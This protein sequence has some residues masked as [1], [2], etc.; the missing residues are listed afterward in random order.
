MPTNNPRPEPVIPDHEVLRKIG[1]GSYG[2][3]WLARGVT[4]ALRAVKVVYREDFDDVRG[5]EREFEGILKFEPISRD[6]PGLV[7]ILHVGRSPDFSFY[8]YVMELGDDVTSGREINPIE[9]EART[10]SSDTKRTPGRRLATEHCIDCGLRLAEAL[11]HLHDG[12]LAHR[13]VKPSNVIFVNGKAKLADIGLVATRGQRTF[14]GTEG[15]VPPEG[16]GSAQADVY[17]LG[18]VLYEIATGKDRLDFPELPDELPG[19]AERKRWLALNQIICDICEPQLSKRTIASAGELADS[20]RRLQQGKRRK[21]RRRPVGAFFATLLVGGVLALGGWLAL[22]G[23]GLGQQI[24]RSNLG[25]YF[26]ESPPPPAPPKP[27]AQVLVKI[28][29]QPSGAHVFDKIKGKQLEDTPCEIVGPE[30][31]PLSLYLQLEGYNDQP[32]EDVI[33][34]NGEPMPLLVTLVKFTPPVPAQPWVFKQAYRPFGGV[35]D[36]NATDPRSPPAFYHETEGPV[37]K[38]PWEEYLKAKSRPPEVSEFLDVDAVGGGPKQGIVLTSESEANLYCQWLMAEG[39]KTGFLKE[40]HEITPVMLTDFNDPGLSE[41]ARKDGL[42]PF[43]CQVRL[44]TYATLV[45]S[46]IPGGAEVYLRQQSEGFQ[47]SKGVTAEG[48]PLAIPQI[49]PGETSISVIRE[50]YKPLNETFT[51]KPGETKTLSRKL[52]PNQSVVMDKPWENSLGMKF[53]P[54]AKDLMACVWETRVKDY[55]HYVS[56]ANL[57]PP[58]QPNFQQDPNHPIVFVS[59]DDAVAFCTWLTKTERDQERITETHEYRLPTDYEWSSLAGLEGEDPYSTPA[60]RDNQSRAPLPP[61]VGPQ[62]FWYAGWPPPDNFANLADVS[63]GN[64]NLS[65]GRTI[66]GYHDPFKNTA[67]VGSFPPEKLHGLYDLCGNVNEWVSEN[68]SATNPVPSGV[69]RGGGWNTYQANNLYIGAR[70]V[71]PPTFRDD[72]S[73]FRVMLAKMAQPDEK[74]SDSTVPDHG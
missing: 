36:P 41:R 47:A 13:D 50:G 44:V 11:R 4:G 33:K 60:R 65:S 28:S 14:V 27:R 46:T 68:Y 16:P 58:P 25:K 49:R 35:P 73:G 70:T 2:E 38:A 5:F 29:S 39:L 19:G 9:Y 42:H 43:K 57:A 45:I 37:E 56:S 8:Y 61:L 20:L 71:Q 15:F 62:Y 1:G 63:A 64:D 7:N 12:G 17:S 23:S 53:V 10:L 34:D 72:A 54:V 32:V 55:I 52:V 67:P 31:D 48:A 74:T 40:Q 69:L 22:K 6:H 3:V 21:R 59:R 24:T 51:L 66:P 26:E 18:K 30:G